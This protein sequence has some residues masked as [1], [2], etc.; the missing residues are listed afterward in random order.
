MFVM[1]GKKLTVSNLI[2]YGCLS[3]SKITDNFENLQEDTEKCKQK[4]E[5]RILFDSNA[6]S[7]NISTLREYEDTFEMK[8]EMAGKVLERLSEEDDHNAYYINNTEDPVDGNIRKGDA[9]LKDYK[10]TSYESK[11][12]KIKQKMQQLV[13]RNTEMEERI[14]CGARDA[15]MCEDKQWKYFLKKQKLIQLAVTKLWQK[16]GFDSSRLIQDKEYNVYMTEYDLHR[17]R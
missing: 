12:R 8:T 3:A 10:L 5:R 13:H 9:M 1:N 2:D 14:E 15:D 16:E 4:H 11:M 7:K 6:T 17:K